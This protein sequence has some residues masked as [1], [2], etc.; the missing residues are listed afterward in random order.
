MAFARTAWSVERRA[1]VKML[2]LK[3]STV[4]WSTAWSCARKLVACRFTAGSASFMLELT[5]TA[6]TSSRGM[7]S[8]AKFVIRCGLSSSKTLKSPAARLRDEAAFAVGDDRRDLDDVHVH[9]FRVFDRLRPRGG[10]QPLAAAEHDDGADGVF[11]HLFARVPFA[12]ERRD[13][14]GAD[15]APVREPADF[16]H[17]RQHAQR[18]EREREADRAHDVGAI[19][20][21]RDLRGRRLAGGAHDLECGEHGDDD[22]AAA[23]HW[24]DFLVAGTS[25]P[26][27]VSAAT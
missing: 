24:W 2:S 12:R 15:L 9:R 11:L 18:L 1:S 19:R 8:D 23:N 20:G 22:E 3:P 27:A 21:R 14:R 5:S 13:G 6:A 7:F 10:D 25:G 16:A 26:A 4:T 17:R